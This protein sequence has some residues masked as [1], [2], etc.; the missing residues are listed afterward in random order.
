MPLEALTFIDEFGSH[1]AMTRSR[2]RAPEGVRAEMVEPFEGGEN[3]STIAALGLR[4]VFAPMMI[5]GA[6]DSAI[7]GWKRCLSLSYAVMSGSCSTK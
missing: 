7:F 6:I 4:G 3:L 1:L 2:A 5:E